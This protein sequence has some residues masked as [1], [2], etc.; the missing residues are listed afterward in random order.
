MEL[1]SADIIVSIFSILVGI[2]IIGFWLRLSYKKLVFE[3][4][5][6]RSPIET[7][8]HV[9]AELM[10]AAVLLEG[11]AA[12]LLHLTLGK[13]ISLVGLGMLVYATINGIGYYARREDKSMVRTFYAVLV[14]TIIVIIFELVS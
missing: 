9:A 3:P 2:S 5:S 7:E 1:S 12:L 14:F 13:G 4:G 8:Y 6:T 11:G 10:T